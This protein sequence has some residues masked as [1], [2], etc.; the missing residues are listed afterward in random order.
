[1]SDFLNYCIIC[2]LLRRE[3]PSKLISFFTT[4]YMST[5]KFAA[6]L[7]RYFLLALFNLYWGI[8]INVNIII[9]IVC[10][11]DYRLIRKEIAS[12]EQKAFLYYIDLN[13]G[14]FP[15]R[16]DNESSYT[17]NES[18]QVYRYWRKSRCSANFSCFCNK[19]CYKSIFK[20]Y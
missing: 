6:L 18:L 19:I 15:Y 1:M 4:S 2:Q 14:H 16:I 5:I 7:R 20:F 12:S 9:I 3:W 10:I 17:N 11:S 13:Y 8:N